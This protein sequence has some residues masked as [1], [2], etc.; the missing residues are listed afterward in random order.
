MTTRGEDAV[1][2]TGI[3]AGRHPPSTQH[4]QPQAATPTS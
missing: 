1:T 3:S 2:G 4:G